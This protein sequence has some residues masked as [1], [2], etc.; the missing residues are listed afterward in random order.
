MVDGGGR[1]CHCW[2]WWPLSS[3]WWSMWMVAVAV[4]VD[5]VGGW[6]LSSH[7]WSTHSS[8]GHGVVDNVGGGHCHR[9]GG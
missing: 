3:H 2:P 8:G 1:C 6:L 7:W 9:V 5:N 4:M